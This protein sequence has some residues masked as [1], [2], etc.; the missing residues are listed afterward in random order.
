MCVVLNA[1]P[2]LVAHLRLVHDVAVELVDALGQKF[3]SLSLDDEA[4]TLGAA[5]HDLGKTLHP[6]ELVGPG[7][8]HEDSGPPLLEQHGLPPYLARFARTHGRWSGERL[9][10]KVVALA[11]NLWTGRRH[12]V[13]EAAIVEELAGRSSCDAWHV[14][15]EFDSTCERIAGRGEE[16]L[17]WQRAGFGS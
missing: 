6:D 5:I 13:L 2:R 15:T 12:D 14:F 3:P 4:V 7:S 1:P 17:A 8:L 10:D 9:E 11:D 16:A